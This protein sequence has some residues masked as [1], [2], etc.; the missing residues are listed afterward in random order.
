[1]PEV[2]Q[3]EPL[4]KGN[5]HAMMK[6]Q[7]NLVNRRRAPVCSAGI[8]VL[9]IMSLAINATAFA[10][11]APQ[12]AISST[13]TERQY[14]AALRAADST[15]F[16]KEFETEFLLILNKTLRQSYDSLATIVERK[17]FIEYYWKAS[18]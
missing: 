7:H 14:F 5:S 9:A 2:R 18:N 4:E 8:L 17:A 16:Q 6:D 10:V 12:P 13:Q 15:K 3:I 1:M 11:Q